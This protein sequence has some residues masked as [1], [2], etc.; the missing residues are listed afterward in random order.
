MI[1][2]KIDTEKNTE[3]VLCLSE[4]D[5]SEMIINNIINN[6]NMQIDVF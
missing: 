4:Y 6:D 2:S 5:P 3:S 1:N